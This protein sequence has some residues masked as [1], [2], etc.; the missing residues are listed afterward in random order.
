MSKAKQLAKALGGKWTYD[1]MS[2]WHRDCGTMHV[3]RCSPGTDQFGDPLP[4]S[5]YWLYGDGAPRRAEIHLEI[6][7]GS[8]FVLL[9]KE[10]CNV[11]G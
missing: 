10:V 9:S 1:G 7:K 2:S 8:V 3:S 11:P 4:G 5:E 6:G